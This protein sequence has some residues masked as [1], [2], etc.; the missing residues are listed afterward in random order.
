MSALTDL[1]AEFVNQYF[2]CG[3][4]A[5]EAVV[6]AGYKVKN[7]NV[8]GVIG[9]ENLR[10]PKI[11]NAIDERLQENAMSADEVIYRLSEQARGSHIDFWDVSDRGFPK[12]NLKKAEER[13]KMHIVKKIKVSQ[14]EH[15]PSLEIEL[16]DAQSALVQLG[17]YYKLFTDKV[18][19]T[20]WQSEAVLSIRSGEVQYAELAEEFGDD[21]A[22]QLFR[23]AGVPISVAS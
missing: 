20:D 21:L 11:R 17:R 1:Q 12:L 3:L 13:G 14:S 19:V 18:E 9:S 4:N 5:T 23:Q 15:G 7:R 8:A 6:Q 2:L 16:Y 10:K 22:T